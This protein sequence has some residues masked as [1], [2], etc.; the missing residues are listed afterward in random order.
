MSRQQKSEY[1]ELREVRKVV[2]SED[3]EQIH[4]QDFSWRFWP[5]V[6]IY[7]YGERRTICKEVIKDTIWTFR[8]K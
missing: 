3:I 6:P 4:P 5:V 2:E 8:P 1:W 7:P